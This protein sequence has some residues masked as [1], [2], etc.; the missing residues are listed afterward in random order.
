MG[1]PIREYLLVGLSAAIVTYLVTGL[2]RRLALRLGAIAVPRGRD[3]HTVPIPRLGGVAIY[4]G[5]VG[6]VFVAMQLPVLRRAFAYSSETVA[7]LVAGGPVRVGRGA[8]DP[9]G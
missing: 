3:V 5:V 6:G 7:V 1:L 9:V 4:L 2:V 8:G